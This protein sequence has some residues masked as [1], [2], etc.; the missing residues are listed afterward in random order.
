MSGSGRAHFKFEPLPLLA[1]NVESAILAREGP[2]F[3]SPPE[4]S[5]QKNHPIP[6][7]RSTHRLRS[8]HRFVQSTVREER[9]TGDDT[10]STIEV[11]E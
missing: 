10:P 11:S 6:I 3:V 7:A 5:Y 8:R 4:R 9:T 1:V 2:E